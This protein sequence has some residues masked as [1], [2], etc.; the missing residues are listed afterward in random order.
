MLILETNQNILFQSNQKLT[1]I[2]QT[3]KVGKTIVNFGYH[4]INKLY[5]SGE[6]SDQEKQKL[7]QYV[8]KCEK[9]LNYTEKYIKRYHP[10]LFKK[11]INESKKL[12][13]EDR[14]S[15]LRS[16]NDRINIS[17]EHFNA[18]ISYIFPLLKFLKSSS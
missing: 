7:I 2:I 9:R 17:E 16:Q 1:K 10:D 12:N 11:I 4:L 5:H 13:S 15:D 14:E 6:I 3:K 18:K 8:Y